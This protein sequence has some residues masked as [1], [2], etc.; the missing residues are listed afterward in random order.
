MTSELAP[1]WRPVSLKLDQPYYV[2]T[3]A[4]GLVAL[5]QRALLSAELM[6]EPISGSSGIFRA[7]GRWCYSPYQK[8]WIEVGQLSENQYPGKLRQDSRTKTTIMTPGKIRV[9]AIMDNLIINQYYEFKLNL[10]LFLE[11]HSAQITG[12]MRAQ[13]LN[14]TVPATI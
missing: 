8:M 5:T 11:Q 9:D 3:S 4:I 7:A 10:R 1:S 2:Q 12:S 6:I 14:P 13:A